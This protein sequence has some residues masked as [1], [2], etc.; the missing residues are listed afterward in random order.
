M[1]MRKAVHAHCGNAIVLLADPVDLRFQRVL[2]D[3][4]LGR[5]SPAEA[6]AGLNSAIFV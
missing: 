5:K 1:A 6:L 3:H 2:A 4:H